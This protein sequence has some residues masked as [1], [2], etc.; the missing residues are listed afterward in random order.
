MDAQVKPGPHVAPERQ[1]L[2]E[3]ISRQWLP[4]GARVLDLCPAGCFSRLLKGAAGPSGPCPISP[5]HPAPDGVLHHPFLVDEAKEADILVLM[6]PGT[7][8]P[9]WQECLV[10]VSRVG[11]PFLFLHGPDPGP[12]DTRLFSS[13][14]VLDL[15]GRHGLEL[16]RHEPLSHGYGLIKCYSKGEAALPQPKR[17]AVLSYSNIGNFGDRLGAQIVRRL[18]PGHVVQKELFFNPWEIS[19]ERFDLLILGVGNSLFNPLMHDHLLE[20]MERSR[21]VIGLFGTQYRPHIEENRIRTVLSRLSF[22]WA[23][24]EE[25]LLL[26]GRHA[27]H[28]AHFGDLLISEF[29]ITQ[30]TMDGCLTIGEEILEGQ[31]LDRTI[32]TIQSFKRVHSDRMHP[33]LCALTSALEVSYSER[34]F[35]G[36]STG[37]MRSMLLDIFGRTFAEG[38]PFPVDRPAVVRY[39]R[40]VLDNMQRLEDQI[41]RAVA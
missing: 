26:Y 37:K 32:R 25:D 12:G 5:S 6:C 22:W 2:A 8:E 13:Q 3:S 16:Q 19:S 23:R 1:T 9:W 20:L 41:A 4:L 28:C 29:P 7:S 35:K 31:P 38:P 17:V 18:L 21:Q 33:L 24:H 36:I 39:R 10:Q 14:M 30:A 40:K 11:K 34:Q 15:L 27:R